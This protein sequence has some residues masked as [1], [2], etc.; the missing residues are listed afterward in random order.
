MVAMGG[1]VAMDKCIP[2]APAR[3]Q[4]CMEDEHMN[5][6]T[7]N[8]PLPLAELKARFKRFLDG[9]P[10]DDLTFKALYMLTV[11]EFNEELILAFDLAFSAIEGIRSSPGDVNNAVV[12]AE[13]DLRERVEGPGLQERIEDL[14]EALFWDLLRMSGMSEEDFQRLDDQMGEVKRVPRPTYSAPIPA[15]VLRGFLAGAPLKQDAAL[16]LEVGDALSSLELTPVHVEAD[17]P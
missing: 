9:H 12:A 17:A 4:P 8:D 5:K 15:D 11:V 7:P 13:Q 2:A 16:G 3:C 14:T 1:G 6:K 10:E